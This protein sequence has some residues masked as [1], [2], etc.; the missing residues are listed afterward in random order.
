MDKPREG[1]IDVH[2]I[3]FSMPDTSRDEYLISGLELRKLRDKLDEKLVD[4]ATIAERATDI[5]KTAQATVV[6]TEHSWLQVFTL[7]AEHEYRKAQEAQARTQ[8]IQ[9]L[10]EKLQAQDDEARAMAA[11][12]LPLEEGRLAISL[13]R[14][15]AS[16]ERPPR[17]TPD[18]I[19]RSDK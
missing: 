15:L 8:E 17:M 5:V 16:V 13:A 2:G 6:L 3:L 18:L 1:V 10:R 14:K 4:Y 12:G 19:H 9:W 11:T 7:L